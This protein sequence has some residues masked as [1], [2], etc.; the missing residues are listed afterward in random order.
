[1]LHLLVSDNVLT[2]HL[3]VDDRPF[4]GN[5][6][7]RSM[8]EPGRARWACSSETGAPY[9]FR[10]GHGPGWDVHFLTLTGDTTVMAKSRRRIYAREVLKDIENGL[11]S[12]ELREKYKLSEQGLESLY[13]KLYS[14][15]AVRIGA[16][17]VILKTPPENLVEKSQPNSG[18]QEWKDARNTGLEKNK[19]K[20][21]VPKD[22]WL[23]VSCGKVLTKDHEKCPSCSG[24]GSEDHDAVG[25]EQETQDPGLEK[26]RAPRRSEQV[27]RITAP[28]I[29]GTSVDLQMILGGLGAMFLF[30]GTFTPIVQVPIV[31]GLNYFQI[32]SVAQGV[33]VGGYLFMGI[34]AVC[35]VL[36]L[37]RKFVWL[38]LPHLCSVALLAYTFIQYRRTVG[39]LD[40]RVDEVRSRLQAGI[41]TTPQGSDT[42][43]DLG[44]F[45]E[46]F[47]DQLPELIGLD[48][49]WLVLILGMALILVSAL[50]GTMKLAA[51]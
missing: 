38:W 21:R 30:F 36:V 40:A 26:K 48:W 6:Q 29:S 4:A 45:A 41:S 42:S 20:V 47:A 50:M 5:L 16:D 24:A 28:G 35:M 8:R 23:C 37:L 12:G 17:S 46:Q 34:A 51:D 15:R 11:S 39:D 13:R 1:M 18:P 7:N 33:A 44:L 43:V 9:V 10:H 31:G 22:E 32:D 27:D 19:R 14:H 25:P 49:G 2:V 3:S